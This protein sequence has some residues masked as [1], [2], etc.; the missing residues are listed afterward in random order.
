MVAGEEKNKE[1]G[2]GGCMC[3]YA[4][5]CAAR[6]CRCARATQDPPLA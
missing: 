3:V 2:V 6:A 4:R 5:A 1:R